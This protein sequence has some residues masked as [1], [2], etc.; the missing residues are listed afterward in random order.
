LISGFFR[1]VLGDDFSTFKSLFRILSTCDCFDLFSTINTSPLSASTIRTLGRVKFELFHMV[2]VRRNQMKNGIY[3][4]FDQTFL[5]VL[6]LK[7]VEDSVEVFCVRPS[8]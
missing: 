1:D 7:N 5:N 6:E 8:I 2:F 4:K 3:V